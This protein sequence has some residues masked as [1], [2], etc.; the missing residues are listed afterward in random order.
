M[1]TSRDL[2]HVRQHMRAC[3]CKSHASAH[4][5]ADAVQNLFVATPSERIANNHSPGARGLSARTLEHLS[6]GGIKVR[7]RARPPA[8]SALPEIV[9]AHAWCAATWGV[10]ALR[11]LHMQALVH[12]IRACAEPPCTQPCP[13]SAASS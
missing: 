9:W 7:P 2:Q 4:V 6:P 5:R 10:V 13:A 12:W 1:R 8:C 3:M 11:V